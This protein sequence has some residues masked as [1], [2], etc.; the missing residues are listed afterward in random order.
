M[1]MIDQA[2]AFA[3]QA[4]DGQVR[5]QT[6][7]PYITHPFSVAL[8]LQKLNCSDELIA[9]GLLHDTVED[10]SVSLADIARQ[11]GPEVAAIVEGCSEPDR[12]LPWEVRKQ[13]TIDHLRDAP[14][15]VK[16]VACADKLDNLRAIWADYQQLGDRVWERFNRGR[17]KQAWYYQNL[18]RSL[19]HG[20]QDRERYPLFQQFEDLVQRV[21]GS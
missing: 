21:F 19:A 8:M 7:I 18:A 10:T 14:L 12:S 5:K 6:N 11:F 9:A 13:H 2:I 1:T 15:E 4:H 16:V 3:A 17:E 20:V